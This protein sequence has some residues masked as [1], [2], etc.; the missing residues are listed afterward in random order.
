MVW[1]VKA[2]LR[3]REC[4]TIKFSKNYYPHIMPNKS[5]LKGKSSSKIKKQSKNQKNFKIHRNACAGPRSNMV[6]RGQGAENLLIL[7]TTSSL[8]YSQNT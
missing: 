5:D 8:K 6:I 1:I 4:H 3:Q 7:F 2:N